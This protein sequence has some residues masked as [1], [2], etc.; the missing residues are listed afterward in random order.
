VEPIWSAAFGLGAA[1]GPN[2]AWD[3]VKFLWR[4]LHEKGVIEATID[5]VAGEFLAERGI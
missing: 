1:M 3:L 4:S 2:A 5:D